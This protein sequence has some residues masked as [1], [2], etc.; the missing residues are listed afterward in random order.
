MTL[1]QFNHYGL[2]VNKFSMNIVW[3]LG[4]KG[5]FSI[6]TKVVP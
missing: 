3:K 2:T 6:G 1:F 5:H 4:K